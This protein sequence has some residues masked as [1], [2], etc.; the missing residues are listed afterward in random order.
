MNMVDDRTLEQRV[1]DTLWCFVSTDKEFEKVMKEYNYDH[2]AVDEVLDELIGKWMKLHSSFY[3]ESMSDIKIINLD[4]ISECADNFKEM[5][6]LLN[7]LYINTYTFIDVISSLYDAREESTIDYT[8]KSDQA[9]QLFGEIFK[10]SVL[11]KEAK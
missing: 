10:Y 9:E 4:C 5:Q 11:Y 6:E 2:E 8:A 7:E 3:S 1:I